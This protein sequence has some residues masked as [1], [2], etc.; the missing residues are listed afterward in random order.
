[1]TKDQ[2]LISISIIIL[3]FT[4]MIDWDVYS[5]LILLAIILVLFASYFK[6]R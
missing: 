4:A 2:V 3:L 5:W 1:M 6:S